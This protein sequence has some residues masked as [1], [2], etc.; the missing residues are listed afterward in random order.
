MAEEETKA[1]W[2][3]AFEPSDRDLNR[4]ADHI[5]STGK[6]QDLTHLARLVIGEVLHSTP[7][8]V[9]RDHDAKTEHASVQLWD[10]AGEWEVGDQVIVAVRLRLD[11]FEPQVGEVT[12]VDTD[13]VHIF[14]AGSGQSKTYMR[15]QPG[16]READ[17]WHLLV[18]SVAEAKARA[19]DEREQIDGIILTYGEQ[20]I[21]QLLNALRAD[22]RFLCA[23]GMWYL[24][25][26]A[27]QP[28]QAQVA[29]LAW[30]MT[31]LDEA[32]RTCELLALVKPPLPDGD[33]G[34]FGLYIA[35]G[36][37]PGLFKTAAGDQGL[38]WALCGDP[39]G[40]CMAEHAAYDPDT[41]EVLCLP[42]HPVGDKAARR[43][44][45]LNLVEAFA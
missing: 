27:A 30:R 15:A 44:L 37:R 18:K 35:L 39:P 4:I 11:R 17:A 41:Y 12:G 26:L 29:G 20:I 14:I 19:E 32:V 16:S 24:T 34:L 38:C 21:S 31:R 13:R 3:E 28:N 7:Q 9:E 22:D 25:Q 36:Q 45:E 8:Q 2:G 23:D 43:L 33:Q 1:P 10:P 40:G 42:H 5:R 6:A